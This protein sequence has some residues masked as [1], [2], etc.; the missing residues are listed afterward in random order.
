[1]DEDNSGKLR[2]ER[3]NRTTNIL[4]G[5]CES[6]HFTIITDYITINRHLGYERVYLPLNQ[7][8]DTPFRIKCM[9]RLAHDMQTTVAYHID[10]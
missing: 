10:I 3:A 4:M 9:F 5:N 6:S 8:A 7:V 2:L 1:M